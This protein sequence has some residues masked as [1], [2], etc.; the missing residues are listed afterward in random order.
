MEVLK[1]LTRPTGFSLRPSLLSLLE[2]LEAAVDSNM[3]QPVAPEYG[4][5]I[6]Y[7]V[8]ASVG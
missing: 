2:D 5:R 3:A 7:V 4:Q 6:D 1:L 8:R